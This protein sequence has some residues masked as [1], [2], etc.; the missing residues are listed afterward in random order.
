MTKRPI[1]AFN[2]IFPRLSQCWAMTPFELSLQSELDVE[3][4]RFDNEWLFKW[5]GMTYE[6][7]ITDV[8]NFL[9]GRIHYGGTKFGDQ[10]QQVFWQALQRY[11]SQKVSEIYKRWDA[12]TRTYQPAIRKSSLDGTERLLN[13]FAARVMV[14]ATET[15]RA[16][17]G[18]G[19]PR[20]VMEYDH[21]PQSG[22][23]SYE[24]GM[25]A[26]AHRLLLG[27]KDLK[28][29]PLLRAQRKWLETFYAENKGL[30]WAAGL[31]LTGA[32]TAFRFFLG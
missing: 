16:L 22:R 19:D 30:I 11:L 20:N 23:I 10:Q 27:K 18:G 28:G 29:E 15:D 6:G 32:A 7:G 13:Q 14:R 5:R 1:A 25:L 26:Q 4:L 31:L 24:I 3:A 9:G 17:R 21:R 2:G 8:D 12:D